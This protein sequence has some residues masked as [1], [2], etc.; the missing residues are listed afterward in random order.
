MQVIALNI[1]DVGISYLNTRKI[2]SAMTRV[3]RDKE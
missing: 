2:I 3:I 1:A